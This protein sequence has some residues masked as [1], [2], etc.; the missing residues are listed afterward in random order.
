MGVSADGWV[1]VG[2]VGAGWI[3][4]PTFPSTDYIARKTTKY[5]RGIVLYLSMMV[6]HS[7][8]E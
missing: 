3:R 2:G 4:T 6:R 8:H 7:R 5:K 1:V